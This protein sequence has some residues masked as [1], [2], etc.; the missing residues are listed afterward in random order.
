LAGLGGAGSLSPATAEGI[1]LRMAARVT[2]RL[3][4][5]VIRV[6]VAFAM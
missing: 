2:A 3:M 4:S 1:G 6:L 5:R